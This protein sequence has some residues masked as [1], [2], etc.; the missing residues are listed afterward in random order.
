MHHSNSCTLVL[1]DLMVN[2]IN[3]HETVRVSVERPR[4]LTWEKFLALIFTSF[5]ISCCLCTVSSSSLFSASSLLLLSSSSI[6]LRVWVSRSY[7]IERCRQNSVQDR[8]RH[9]YLRSVLIQCSYCY[10]VW[11]TLDSMSR[12]FSSCASF[13]IFSISSIFNAPIPLALRNRSKS[14]LTWC[15][16]V[17]G[18]RFSEELCKWFIKPK[19]WTG[20]G[21]DSLEKIDKKLWRLDARLI[22]MNKSVCHRCMVPSSNLQAGSERS[23]PKDLE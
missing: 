2:A 10:D 23:I 20:Y 12:A 7:R 21:F 13:S 22:A 17:S 5:S 9:F 6:I 18:F 8:W 11:L 3:K 16:C 4:L 15:V 14:L 19:I 1:S